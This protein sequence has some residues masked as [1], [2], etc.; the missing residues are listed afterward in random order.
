MVSYLR[1]HGP[2]A[3]HERMHH[4]HDDGLLEQAAVDKHLLL[5]IR[6]VLQEAVVLVRAPEPLDL[7]IDN[8]GV[9]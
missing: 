1:R 2:P 8:G 6:M 7:G 3:L 4:L 9:L 5:I